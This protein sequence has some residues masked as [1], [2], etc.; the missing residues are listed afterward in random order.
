MV[1]G[2]GPGRL[3]VHVAGGQRLSFGLADLI[4]M[5]LAVAEIGNPGA[6]R[7]GCL[8]A[9]QE[10]RSHRDHAA[11][12]RHRYGGR[13]VRIRNSRRANRSLLVFMG[14]VSLSCWVLLEL[15]RPEELLPLAGAALNGNRGVHLAITTNILS[16]RKWQVRCVFVSVCIRLYRHRRRTCRQPQ[17]GL[18]LRLRRPNGPNPAPSKGASQGLSAAAVPCD[19][20][21]HESQAK[22]DPTIRQVVLQPHEGLKYSFSFG[23]RDSVPIVVN[24]HNDGPID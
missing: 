18:T 5:D 2:L 3:E 23:F 12:G 8:G 21:S 13:V 24:V 22:P 7:A 17:T 11:G 9:G 14:C 19:D 15:K 10:R 20:P 1:A 6:L 4:D 16:R